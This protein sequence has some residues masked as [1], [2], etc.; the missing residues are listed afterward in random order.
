MKTFKPFIGAVLLTATLAFS[1]SC[2][3]SQANQGIAKPAKVNLKLQK[4]ADGLQS[5]VAAVF[6]NNDKLLVCEQYGVVR[7]VEK[8]KINPVPFLDLDK[9]VVRV[10]PGYDERG[11]LGIALHPK[12]S[13]NKKF[14]VYYSAPS[15]AS[16]SNNKITLSEFTVSDNPDVANP[17]SEKVLLTVED[18]ESNHN[19]GDIHFGPDGFLYISIGDGGGAGDKHGT[20]GNGQNLNTLLGKILRIDVDKGSTYTVPADNPFVGKNAKPEIWAYG[21]RNTWKFS[22]DSKSGKLFGADVGQNTYEEVNI[23]EKG[24]NYGWRVMEATHCFNPE[25]GCKIEGLIKPITEY[26]HQVGISITGGFVYN[27]KA[28][29]EITGNYIF[30]DWTGKLF[31]LENSGK[32]WNQSQVA[33]DPEMNIRILS[34]AEDTNGEIYAFTSEDNG[35]LSKKGAIYKV[36][37]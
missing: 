27:G 1:Y 19:G 25:N 35:P 12:F 33:L 4:V 17:S 18:P 24:G 34:F 29:P 22:F 2:T 31:L 14:Y 28:I 36:T 3:S 5:P 6:L 8:G 26:T 21:L 10:N 30:A 32:A 23:I 16:G 9:K 37:K 20:I 13:S 15:N 11:L 7:V